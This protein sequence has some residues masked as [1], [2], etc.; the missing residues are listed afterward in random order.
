MLDRD[1]WEAGT[2]LT[3]DSPN[4]PIE[5]EVTAIPFE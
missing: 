1:C 2:H 3:V 5:A 4:G